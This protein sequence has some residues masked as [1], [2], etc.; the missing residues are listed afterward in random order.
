M[1]T[2]NKTLFAAIL[3]L[4]GINAQFL[5]AVKEIS[6]DGPPTARRTQDGFITTG[7]ALDLREYGELEGVAIRIETSGVPN[8]FFE[9]LNV[10]GIWSSQVN[11]QI[12]PEPLSN[13]MIASYRG[14]EVFG[15]IAVRY[16]IESKELVKFLKGGVFESIAEEFP[17]DNQIPPMQIK[18]SNVDKPKVILRSEWGARPPKYDY[19]N[20]PYF[21]KMTLHHAAGWAARS[22]DEGKAA[23]KSIQEFHQDGRGWSDIGYHFIVDMAGNIYQGRPETV[24]GA[25]VGGANTGNIG[26]C[27]LGCYHPPETSWTCLDEMTSETEKSLI[28]LYSWIADSYDVDPNVLKGHR[29]YFGTTACPGDNVWLMIP[30][31]K[32]DIVLFIQYGNQPTRYALFQNFP[33]PFNTTTT[34]H[35]DIPE[36]GHVRITIFDILGR[37]VIQLV[38][39]E[40]HYG[41]K[42]IDWDGKDINGRLVAPGVYFYQAEMGPLTE[43]KKMILLK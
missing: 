5:D 11:A 39:S 38:N 34:L 32:A 10:N 19:S 14:T 31:M 16:I 12:F 30:Q 18:K 1:G 4:N 21:N 41:Y 3:I 25:H 28:H 2:L 7:S 22:L 40:Q 13:R 33:N 43:T 20:H 36:T 35:Y 42:R 23:V 17:P 37:E 24:L 26:V 6:F 8:V 15:S 27:I 9:F 29:D